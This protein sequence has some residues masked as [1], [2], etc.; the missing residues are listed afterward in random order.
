MRVIATIFFL[1]FSLELFSQTSIVTEPTKLDTL[2]NHEERIASISKGF[3]FFDPYFD[4]DF[5]D[6]LEKWPNI[7][8]KPLIYKRAVDDFFPTLHVWYFYDND[9]TVRFIKYNWGFANTEVLA[10]NDEIRNQKS[11]KK[12]YLRKYKTEKE[13]LKK[14]LGDPTI[15]DEKEDSESFYHLSTS[16][17]TPE[18][19]VIINMT[20]DQ[21][22]IEFES[23]AIGKSIVVPRSG[24]EIKILF[25]EN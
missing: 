19:R 22:I 21:S 6:I 23:K 24:I 13:Y 20:V 9:T 2:I 8:K 7:L 15:E 25:K 10:S 18:K 4:E 14:I 5:E 16:W 1:V 17:D 12:D 3:Q 11:R